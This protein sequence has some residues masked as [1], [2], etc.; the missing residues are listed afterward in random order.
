MNFHNGDPPILLATSVAGRGLDVKN[1]NLVVNYDAPLGPEDYVHR[2]GRTGRAGKKG[3]S[4]TLL[5]LVTDGT[6]MEYI[7][8]VMERTGLL[9][10]P[11]LAEQ[12]AMRQGRSTRIDRL[13]AAAAAGQLG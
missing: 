13:T 9:V 6:A 5:S 7:G 1:V 8:E 10:P 3:V 11:N 4:I 12:L 2:I